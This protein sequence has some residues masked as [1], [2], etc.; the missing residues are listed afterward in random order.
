MH[1]DKHPVSRPDY[2]SLNVPGLLQ[3]Y[4][5]PSQEWRQ[6][7]LA[8]TGTQLELL[9]KYGLI[10]GNAPALKAELDRVV[11]RFS[12]YTKLGQ[13]FVLTGAIDKWMASCDR[14]NT[15]AAYEDR[16]PLEKRIATFLKARNGRA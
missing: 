7:I 15:Q 9:Q 6:R 4:A 10:E 14:K 3:R 2:I 1:S 8:L 11:I 13:E 5:N 16:A 12:D